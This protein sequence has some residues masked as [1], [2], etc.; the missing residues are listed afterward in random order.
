MAYRIPERR[1]AVEC[2]NG[3][4]SP[5]YSLAVDIEITDE[6][7]GGRIRART[8]MLSMLGCVVDTLELFPMGRSVSVKLFHRGA[9]VSTLGKVLY[10][11]SDLG[12]GLAFTI[13]EPEDKRILDWWVTEF[14]S[15]P[16]L[17]R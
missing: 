13:I 16:L 6:Y 3:K 15:I 11:R 9:E 17:K 14:V 2:G 1:R 4:W 8:T 10:A 5:Q 7:L 12:M